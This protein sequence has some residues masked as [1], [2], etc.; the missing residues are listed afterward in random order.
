[1]G[2]TQFEILAGLIPVLRPGNQERLHTYDDPATD[3]KF[4]IRGRLIG[5]G[6][7]YNLTEYVPDGTAVKTDSDGNV[8]EITDYPEIDAAISKWGPNGLAADLHRRGLGELEIVRLGPHTEV[9]FD[10]Q[11]LAEVAA[12]IAAAIQSNRWFRP[13]ASPTLTEAPAA[14]TREERERK[15]LSDHSYLVD[16]GVFRGCTI[17]PCNLLTDDTKDTITRYLD[18]PT[19][20]H[21]LDIRNLIVCG[22][23][24]LWDAWCRDDFSAPRQGRDGFPSADTLRRSIRRQVESDRAT[25]AQIEIEPMAQ[26]R[27]T[28]LSLVPSPRP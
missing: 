6:V 3:R 12:E 9:G 27:F 5:A 4:E 2:I 19:Q 21:W 22:S 17:K 25:L 16:A 24:T 23:A 7:R 14:V 8:L 1:M 11:T 10:Y 26:P 15:R 28:G 20:Q 13:H 18:H